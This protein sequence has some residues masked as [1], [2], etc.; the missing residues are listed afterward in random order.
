MRIHFSLLVCAGL[1]VGC[2]SSST[3]S[4]T[5]STTLSDTVSGGLYLPLT[6]NKSVSGKITGSVS[7]YDQSGAVMRTD[8]VDRNGSGLL[9]VAQ[10]VRG[11]SGRPV[12]GFD[13]DGKQS[14]VLGY[15]GNYDDSLEVYGFRQYSSDQAS[16]LPKHMKV[17]DSWNPA[18]FA[19][20]I[21]PLL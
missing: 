4:D 9:G 1:A 17:G 20:P 21:T 14:R 18:P 2:S 5:T 8:Q 7:Y 13:F 10:I 3:P 15:L 11:I 6:D 12:Y 19:A 16:I